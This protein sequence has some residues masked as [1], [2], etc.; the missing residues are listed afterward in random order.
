MAFG[1]VEL[2]P[3]QYPGS[4][5]NGF[6]VLAAG[7]GFT[8]G[9]VW[10]GGELLVTSIS[11][12][13]LYRVSLS[14]G[15]PEVVALPGGGPNG[16]TWDPA[17]RRVWIAQNGRVHMPPRDSV[18]PQTAGL[19]S[20]AGGEP[21]R[22]HH[23]DAATA[24]ND[25][26]VGPDGRLWFTSPAGDPHHGVAMVGS[27]CALDIT[28]GHVQV[29]WRS[30]G[31]PN[32]LAFGV[33]PHR[34][35]VAETRHGRIVE[36]DLANGELEPVRS[37]GLPRGHPDGIAVSAAGQL[38]VAATS[39]GT[40]E[41]FDADLLPVGSVAF[42]ETSMPTNVCFAGE[43]LTQLVVTLAQ[44]GRVVA[45]TSA[46]PGLPLTNRLARS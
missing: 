19:Q 40:L 14:G 11:R 1:S 44:G 38:L 18:E 29:K 37:V 23:T 2:S 46:L 16:L 28:T 9:P 8:E 22:R 6:R 15:D 12:G 27:V 43:D 26:V 3:P 32:G 36:F 42:E 34:L 24:P 25:C 4:W 21:V 39:S 7:I 45:M 10:A 33:D 31:Y 17:G 35:Y 30:D 5:L 13:A 20:W 41:I